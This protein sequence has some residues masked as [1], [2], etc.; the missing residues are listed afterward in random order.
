MTTA[1]DSSAD[2]SRYEPWPWAASVGGGS[3]PPSVSPSPEACSNHDGLEGRAMRQ[4]VRLAGLVVVLGFAAC[5]SSDGGNTGGAG[6][7]AGST[8]TGG[9]GGTAGSAGSGGAGGVGGNVG[10]GGAGGNSTGGSGGGAPTFYGSP[11]PSVCSAGSYGWQF[12][13]FT[14]GTAIQV[15]AGCTLD[16]SYPAANGFY[17]CQF[18]CW[19]QSLLN[20]NCLGQ[21]HPCA[22]YCAVG[23]TPWDPACVQVP[24]SVLYCC[25]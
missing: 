24:S 12:T 23:M 13:S 10:S 20:P 25:P 3:A 6:G 21:P 8:S 18:S 9:V 1:T 5:S 22:T 7:S 15:P 14:P 11:G 4:V 16:T 17:C 2:D 19:T